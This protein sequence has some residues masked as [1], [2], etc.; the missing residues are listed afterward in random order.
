MKDLPSVGKALSSNSR[1]STTLKKR[2]R[3]G[4]RDEN[5][6]ILDLGFSITLDNDVNIIVMSTD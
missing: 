1:T 3:D 2:K 6:P 5:T 4:K